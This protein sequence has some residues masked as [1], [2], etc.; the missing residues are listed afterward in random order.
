MLTATEV[1]DH[2]GLKAVRINALMGE[3]GLITRDAKRGWAPTNRGKTLGAKACQS[4]DTG[5]GYVL[6]PVT[7]LE[8]TRLVVAV[9]KHLGDKTASIVITPDTKIASPEPGGVVG[10]FRKKYPAGYRADDGHYVRSKGE[11]L[12]DNYLYNYLIVHAYEPK[13]RVE[14]NLCP[15]F[16]IPKGN[17]YIE[18][19]GM[20]DDPE[21]S[22]YKEKK[23]AVYEK[24]KAEYPLI[25][26]RD[27]HLR[28]LDDYLPQELR[29][30]GVKVK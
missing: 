22:R 9:K 7:V 30:Y 25:Q 11:L 20:E 17:V 26:L 27:E 12:I 29:K 15:D 4:E 3:L 16:F 2:F 23:L 24:Y 18:Y 14:E 28:N 1:G 6:W 10:D 13:L 21:Y 8:N 5:K 19:W